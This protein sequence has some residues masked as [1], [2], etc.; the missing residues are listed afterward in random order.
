[1]N[2]QVS[3]FKVDFRPIKH[4]MFTGIYTLQRST[5]MIGEYSGRHSYMG[6]LLVN[7]WGRKETNDNSYTQ[8]DN[9]LTYD[10][11]A[12]K[13]KYVITAGNSYNYENIQTQVT[14]NSD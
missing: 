13:L 5:S 12:G 1:L 9:T 6:G 10:N 4:L 3:T 8:V 2:R 7:G 14:A 11:A